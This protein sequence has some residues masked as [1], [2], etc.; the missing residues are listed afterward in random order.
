MTLKD[1]LERNHYVAF[2][3]IPKKITVNAAKAE[4]R[5]CDRQKNPKKDERRIVGPEI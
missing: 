5:K 4:N 1:S 3:V 2:V